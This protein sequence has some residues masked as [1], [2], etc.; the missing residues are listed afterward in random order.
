MSVNS[1]MLNLFLYFPENK[2]EYIPAVIELMIAIALCFL[3][4]HFIRRSSRK[5]HE[6][7]KELEKKVLE[8]NKQDIQRH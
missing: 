1:W 4:F 5:Q 6:Q 3:V 2:L 8:R 7:A